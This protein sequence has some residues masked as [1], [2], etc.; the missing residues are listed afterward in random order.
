MFGNGGGQG[1]VVNHGCQGDVLNSGGQGGVA[2]NGHQGDVLN[3]GGQG[4]SMK[5]GGCPDTSV[6]EQENNHGLTSNCGVV[7]NPDNPK[8][9]SV[10]PSKNPDGTHT[11]YDY[12]NDDYPNIDSDFGGP[13]LSTILLED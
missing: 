6:P 3:N 4:G 7:W 10:Q 13:Q 11:G 1:R 2:N 9:N 12:T 8:N 5:N